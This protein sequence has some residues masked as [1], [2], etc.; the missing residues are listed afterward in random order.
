MQKKVL[1]IQQIMPEYRVAFFALLK[2]EL[3]K[4]GIALDLIYGAGNTVSD[5]KNDSAL[6]WATR[7]S[8][9]SLSIGKLKLK[10]QPAT[11][12]LADKDLIIVEKAN[13]LIL[14]Y[15]II[16]ARKF[17]KNRL[18]FWGHGRNLQANAQSPRNRIN[19][20]VLKKCDWWWAY[21]KGVKDFLIQNQY[22]PSRIT[23]VQNS[24][25]THSLRMQLAEVDE[26]EIVTLKKQFGITSNHT[27]IY[28]GRMYTEKRL[29]FILETCY[30]VKAKIPEFHMIF[31]GSGPDSKLAEIASASNNWIHFLGAISGRERVKYFKLASIQ[32][33][34]GSV[35][36]GI[37][38]SFA[39]ETPIITT[40]HSQHGPEIEYLENGINGIITRNTLEDYS[41]TVTD[42]LNEYKY[43]E[44]VEGC[45]RSSKEYSIEKMVE[46]FKKGVVSCLN[47]N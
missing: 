37:L 40:I 12:F 34:P 26:S 11:K 20:L 14:N 47:S 23:V 31:I 4:C 27:A 13:K 16:I 42:I 6:P 32:L 36:L 33:I 15:Y 44:L 18:G 5:F 19:R 30:L 9:K 2:A 22:P 7:I 8:S 28:C 21:T 24:I 1:I 39:L 3:E 25:D 46:N 10:W 38:D 43:L 35:G 17:W 45:I 41:K 29:S